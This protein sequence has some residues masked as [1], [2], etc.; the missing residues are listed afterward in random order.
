MK[1]GSFSSLRERASG[2][3]RIALELGQIVGV[4]HPADPVGSLDMDTQRKCV[5]S[6]E[7][8]RANIGQTRKDDVICIEEAGPAMSA[9]MP[10]GM[11]GRGIDLSRAR[12]LQLV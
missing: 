2:R 10:S 12:D 5:R 1:R 4:L 8:G 7:R 9:E 11:L 6:V 3:W